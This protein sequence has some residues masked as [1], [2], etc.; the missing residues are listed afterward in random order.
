MVTSVNNSTSS[1]GSTK[2]VSS[3]S[4][5]NT[6]SS[7]SSTSETQNTG[8]AI[9]SA[10]GGSQIDIQALATNLV[11]AER[12]PLQKLLDDQKTVLDNKISSIGR[13][14]SSANEMKNQLASFGKD[15]RLFAYTPQSSDSSKA[16]FVFKSNPS[17]FNLR[18]EVTQLAT[19]NAVTLEGMDSAASWP[20]TGQLVITQGRRSG[21]TGSAL[22][23][24][25]ADYTSLDG[26]K[27]AIN[28]AGPYKAQ[29]LT[30]VSPTGT[31]RYLSISRGTGAERNFFVSTKNGNSDLT[32]GLYVRTPTYTN[33]VLTT[34]PGQA[35]GVDAK[36]VSGG[37]EY[38][39]F[40]NTFTD[41]MPGV[42][43]TVNAL[44]ET[45]KPVNLSTSVDTSKFT[46]I[47]RQIVSS[48]NNLQGTISDEIKYDLD[49]KKRGG[50]AND[51]VARSFL[52]QMRRMTTDSITTLNGNNVS[53]ASLGVRTNIDGTL[54][55]DETKLTAA[56]QN[57][58]L[59]EAVLSSTTS[60]TG[61]IKGAFEKMN[62]FADMIMGKNGALVTLYN[63][64]EKTDMK[65]YEDKLAK[66]NSDM[67]SLK[68][69][70]MK[71]FISMQDYL[72]TTKSAQN[73]LTQSMT[74][75]TASMKG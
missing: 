9:I 39:N 74:A 1:I 45:N 3:S 68:Q 40:K 53:L 59:M 46:S 75:W 49:V 66:L 58:D 63:K 19:E 44:T 31:T 32:T 51:Y 22:T 64:T 62:D 24:N 4:S 14:Y 47:V 67:D 41:L 37:H 7:T 20:T 35:N 48:Y 38:T 50:L 65:K 10:L 25:Y 11:N 6:A 18:F 30:S 12:A 28:T 55:I 5:S 34:D 23:F 17:N 73:S 56:T 29:V 70:Y 27:D 57:P 15:P 33:G 13:I 8:S 72:N 16:S 2:T 69:R 71:Q 61:T 52:G 42:T 26:L 43:V 60:S 21:T 54:T 36:I